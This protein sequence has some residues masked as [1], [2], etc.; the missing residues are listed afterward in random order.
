MEREG[1]SDFGVDKTIKRLMREGYSRKEA[2]AKALR[3]AGRS[4]RHNKSSR[5]Y[6]QQE[7]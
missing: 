1:R 6:K 7:V 5:K 4:G 3:M 2:V